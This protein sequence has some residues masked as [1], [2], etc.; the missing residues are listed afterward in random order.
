M[1]VEQPP[2]PV[3]PAHPNFVF[4]LDKTLYGLKQAPRAWYERLSTFFL[5]QTVL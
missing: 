1:Y 2:G 4:K 3:D 5:F